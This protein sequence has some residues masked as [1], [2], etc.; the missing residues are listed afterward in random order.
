MRLPIS[1]SGFVSHSSRRGRGPDTSTLSIDLEETALGMVVEFR[2]VPSSTR[3]SG[4]IDSGVKGSEGRGTRH[5][6]AQLRYHSPVAILTA[7]TVDFPICCR[8]CV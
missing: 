8:N 5:R 1:P 3:R 2:L 4:A 6:V 7:L